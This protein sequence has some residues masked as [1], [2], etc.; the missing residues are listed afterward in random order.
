M[1]VAYRVQVTGR[2]LCSPAS[3]SRAWR[4]ARGPIGGWRVRGAHPSQADS[5]PFTTARLLSTPLSSLSGRQVSVTVAL[6]G[7]GQLIRMYPKAPWTLCF[8]G[9]FAGRI[10]ST[11]GRARWAWGAVCWRAGRQTPGKLSRKVRRHLVFLQGGGPVC[12][13]LRRPSLCRCCS[14]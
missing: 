5:P 1:S 14:Q 9:P 11:D 8:P 2:C 3:H 6:A 10:G 12:G 7:L 4:G 13:R